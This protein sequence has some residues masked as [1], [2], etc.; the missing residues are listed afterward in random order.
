MCGL[1]LFAPLEGVAQKFTI[2]RKS[3]SCTIFL[4]VFFNAKQFYRCIHIQLQEFLAFLN[5]SLSFLLRKV[6][7]DYNQHR[8]KRPAEMRAFLTPSGWLAVCIYSFVRPSC[9]RTIL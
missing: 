8:T 9:F 3:L 5:N 2:F 7:L 4:W 1:Y 6:K